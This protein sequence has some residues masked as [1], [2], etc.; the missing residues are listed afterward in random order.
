MTFRGLG[1]IFCASILLLTAII[2]TRAQNPADTPPAPTRA[3]QQRGIDPDFEQRQRDMRLLNKTMSP[4]DGSKTEAPKRRDPKVVM[5][6]IAEDFTRIQVVNNDLGQ[7]TSASAPLNLEF[8][9]KSTAEL[10]DRSKRFGENLG[11]PE[12]AKDSKPPKLEPLTDV[13]QLKSALA[14]LDILINEFTHNPLFTDP[15]T[16]NAESLVK[17]RR[18]LVEINTLSEHIK[19]SAE[20]LNKAVKQ[21]P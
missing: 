20:Q 9:I 13:E 18:N 19:K 11:H 7:A 10:M 16:R 5:A 17:A 14:S 1:Q 8:V 12:P 15:T 3:E 2:T 6:E 4:S 21:S